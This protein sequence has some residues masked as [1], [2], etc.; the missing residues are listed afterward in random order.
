MKEIFDFLDDKEK[1]GLR[2]LC[3]L[4]SGVILFSLLISLPKRRSY[5]NAL[6]SL[7]DKQAGYQQLNK[8]SM[9]EKREWLRWQEALRDMDELKTKY[10]YNDREGIKRL[11][12]DIEQIFNEARIHTSRKKFDYDEFKKEKIKKVSVSFNIR[13]SYLS[14]KRFIHTVEEFPK[15]LVIER[16][17]F[18]N[19]DAGGRM[20]ELK[21]ILAGYSES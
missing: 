7:A 5:F 6:S 15:F 4:L 18:L 21:I 12:L 10:F 14:I 17:D 20:L 2:F 3:I 19:I 13:G 11:R 1:K 9:E 16:I 8:T